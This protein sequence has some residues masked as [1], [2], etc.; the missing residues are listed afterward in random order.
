MI[1][2][3]SQKEN[4]STMK[5]LLKMNKRG[6]MGLGTLQ[7]LVLTLTT[8]AVI[9]TVT[10]TILSTLRDSQTSGSVEY[11]ASDAMITAF[12]DNLVG[13]FSILVLIAVFAIIITLVRV[14]GRTSGE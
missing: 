5:S 10:L 9:T 3:K 8:V 12:S 11:N 2:Y 1:F 4:N 6:A 14:F 13:N 7:P